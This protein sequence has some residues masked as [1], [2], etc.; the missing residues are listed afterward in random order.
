ME[1]IHITG[2]G[3]DTLIGV[4]DWERKRQTRLK[5]NLVLSVDLSDAMA[6]DKVNDTIDYAAVAAHCQSFAGDSRFE[7]LEAFGSALMTSLLDTFSVAEVALTVEKP[8]IL[9]DAEMVAV[10]MAR[11]AN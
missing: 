5:L 2:L 4:Y 6:S 9:P 8:G 1:Q 7:L 3:V 11:A 10:S